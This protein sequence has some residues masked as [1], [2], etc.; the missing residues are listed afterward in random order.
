MTHDAAATPA[1]SGAH[2]VGPLERATMRR[3]TM[4][5]LP[6]LA[7]GY[8]CASLDRANIGMAATRMSPDLGFSNAQFGFGAGIFFLGYLL[9]EI[10]SNL[11]LDR[12]GARRWLARI[13]MTW[14]IVSGLTAFVWDGWS[15]YGIRFVLGLA[16]A[17]FF[18]GVLLYITW[19]FPA[20]Y[21]SRTTALFMAAGV[22]S[23]IVGPPIG[24]LLLRLHGALGLAGWQWLFVVEALPSIATCVVV[25][26]L[27]TD[28]PDEASWLAPEQKAWLTG[29]LAAERAQ[30]EAVRKYS[31]AKAVGSIKMWLLTLVE[32]GHQVAGYGLTFFMPLIVKGL[33]VRTEWIGVVSAIPFLFG[34]AAMIGWGY[35]S[36]RSG[37]RTWH[38]AGALMLVAAGLLVC[39][40]IGAGHP[41][42]TMIALCVTI[43]GNQSVAPCFWSIPSSMLTGTAAAGGLAMINSFGNLGGWFGPWMYGLV[44]DATNSTS[45]ALFS[46]AVGPLLSAIIL[47]ALRHNRQQGV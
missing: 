28:R 42:L 14:G 37:E 31:L 8:F 44:K 46:L 18:P 45:F 25:W 10:P 38:A 39:T 47:I 3:V 4:R 27:L 11:M 24:G 1:G 21:R 36:D 13:L 17:G 23:G 2:A 12:V 35:H 15:F 20:R 41:M 29:R 19:W 9:A 26:R 33:G 43:M 16:E 22:L 30:R 40:A 6:V 5:L 32:F 34:F 7:L